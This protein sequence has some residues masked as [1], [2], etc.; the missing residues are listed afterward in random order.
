MH[1]GEY[2]EDE[3]YDSVEE[4]ME[5]AIDGVASLGEWEAC[6]RA[7]ARWIAKIDGEMDQFAQNR[8]HE[9]D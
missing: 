1:L 8:E 7:I 4:G 2:T 9:I 3:F 6:K 5:D